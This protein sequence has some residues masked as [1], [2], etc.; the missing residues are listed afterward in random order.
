LKAEVVF[1]SNKRF[2]TKIREFEVETD[3]PKEKGGS[4]EAP[5]PP[6]L[7]IASLGSCIG[8]YIT[9]YLEN[10]SVSCNGLKVYLDTEY[11]ETKKYITKISV[12]IDLPTDIGDR[13]G[14]LLKVAKSCLIH[15]TIENN[16]EIDIHLLNKH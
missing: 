15:K 1:L 13:E 10:I 12:K 5:A 14:A 11:S 2:K 16:P 6:E 7:F 4:N 9:N 8:I 3:L